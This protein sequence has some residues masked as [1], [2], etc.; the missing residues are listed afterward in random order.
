MSRTS[1]EWTHRPGTLPEVWNLVTGCNKVS[2]GCK[3]CYAEVMH[4]RLMHM[5][6]SK[7]NK[8]FLDGAV[9]H[10]DITKV[11]TEPIYY[12]T[13]NDMNLLEQLTD[14][15]AEKPEMFQAS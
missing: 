5:M 2:Q 11:I 9:T 7:Y 10:E 4:K 1:I 6:P 12:D 15:R 8:P 3:H 13:T 14:L